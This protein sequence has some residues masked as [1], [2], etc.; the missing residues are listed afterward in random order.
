MGENSQVRV[1]RKVADLDRMIEGRYNLINRLFADIA[2]L[3]AERDE[4]AG[5]ETGAFGKLFGTDLA[6]KAAMQK[7]RERPRVTISSEMEPPPVRLAEAS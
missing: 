5:D 7:V 4:I 3:V 1:A 2:Q 6:A